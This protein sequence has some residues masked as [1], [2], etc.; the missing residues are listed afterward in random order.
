MI[1]DCR[2]MFVCDETEDCFGTW[3]L[4]DDRDSNEYTFSVSHFSLEL[5]SVA[6]VAEI[7]MNKPSPIVSSSS[8]RFVISL[9]GKFDIGSSHR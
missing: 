2:K 6:F 1:V 5:N 8:P 3:L 7:S 9:F 4:I